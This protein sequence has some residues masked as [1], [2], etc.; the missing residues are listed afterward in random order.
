MAAIRPEPCTYTIDAADRITT[1]NEAWLEFARANGAHDLRR[2]DVVGRLLW[3]FVRGEETRAL[4]ERIFERVRGDDV[5]L[6]IPFWC[7]SPD[8]RREMRMRVSH[9]LRGQLR[10]DGILVR[11]ERRPFV[12]VLAMGAKRTGVPLPMCSFCRRVSTPEGEWLETEDAVARLRL[13]S[14]DVPPIGHCVCGR[15]REVVEDRIEGA[16]AR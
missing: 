3:G 13:F 6:L 15:C 11:E 8:C 7:D 14:G 4:W 10:L 9:G 16:R 1:V 2:E 5:D 12:S